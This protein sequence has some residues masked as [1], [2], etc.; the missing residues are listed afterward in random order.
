MSEYQEHPIVK[1]SELAYQR[2][3]LIINQVI[4]LEFYLDR[5]IANCLTDTEDKRDRMC[6]MVLQGIPLMQKIKIIENLA[7]E[8]DHNLIHS[9]PTVF[10]DLE[11][12]RKV[13]NTMAHTILHVEDT[14]VGNRHKLKPGLVKFNKGKRKP[15][16]YNE[17]SINELSEL[18]RGYIVRFMVWRPFYTYVGAP[19][20]LPPRKG[21]K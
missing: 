9:M 21:K 20:T 8:V 7:Y 14:F 16:E 19:S 17:K 1:Y 5:Y 13:R 12:I 15:I 6:E 4:D 18:I 2:R 10:K 3:G 11:R